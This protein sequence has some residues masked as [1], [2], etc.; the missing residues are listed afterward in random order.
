MEVLHKK[1]YGVASVESITEAAGVPKGSFF[2]H[3]HSK[4]EFAAEALRAYFQPWSEKSEVILQRTDLAPKDKLL[5]LLRVAT[6]KSRGCY[7]GCMIGNLSLELAHQSEPLRLLLAKI[8]DAWTSSFEQ[9]IREGQEAGHF[10]T[11]LAA[12]KTARF[13]VNLFQGSILR[14]KVDHT[15]RATEEFE[16]TVLSVLA[17]PVSIHRRVALTAR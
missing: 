12:D 7:D 8:L 3:F 5:G 10:Q 1:G 11:S 14:A 6:S 4:E 15:D 16:D 13:I 2:N 17:N 9:V